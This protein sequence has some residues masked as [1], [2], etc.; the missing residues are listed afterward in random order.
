MQEWLSFSDAQIPYVAGGTN[1][2]GIVVTPDNR[3]LL[4]V[5]STSGK[6]YRIGIATKE[7]REVTLSEPINAGDGLLLEGTKLYVCRNATN[8]IYPVAMNGDYLSGTV[9]TPFGEGLLFNTTMARAGAYLLVVN[10]Q[11]NQRGTGNQQLPFSV[12]R[13]VVP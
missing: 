3:Y 11:L 5:V 4:V 7:I 1:A 9:G 8:R 10:G 12:S 13:V 2:N 6:L